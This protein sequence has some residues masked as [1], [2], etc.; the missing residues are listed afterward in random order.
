MAPTGSL[1]AVLS[2]PFTTDQAG[3]WLLQ[4]N[5]GA[6]LDGHRVAIMLLLWVLVDSRVLQKQQARMLTP[7]SMYTSHYH[8]P[9]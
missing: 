7:L 6:Q 1:A 3:L 4:L 9:G 2:V 8:L 5:R